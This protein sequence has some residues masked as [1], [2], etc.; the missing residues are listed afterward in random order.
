MRRPTRLGCLRAARQIQ[1][2]CPRRKVENDRIQ[3]M[4]EK[5]TANG[6]VRADRIVDRAEK[7]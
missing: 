7:D 3:Q 6:E 5:M 4:P 2:E 1:Q